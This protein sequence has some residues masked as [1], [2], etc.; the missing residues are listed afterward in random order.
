M[1]KKLLKY[2]LKYLF[3]RTFVLFIVVFGLSIFK[4]ITDLLPNNRLTSI[5]S[6]S[7]TFL[8]IGSL[9][10]LPIF[11]FVMT[12]QRYRR[13]MLSDEGYLTHTLPV[14]ESKILLS[15]LVAN[16]IISIASVLMVVAGLLI[17]LATGDFFVDAGEF[18]REVFYD[19]ANISS[20]WVALYLILGIIIIIL[21]IVLATIF[22]PLCQTLST[23]FEDKRGLFTILFM[24]VIMVGMEIIM[25]IV[26][27]IIM[28]AV[29]N[30]ALSNGAVAGVMIIY[31]FV[32]T[33]GIVAMYFGILAIIKK[34]LNLK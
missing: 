4:R 1:F 24:F 34:R 9:F 25:S 5:I 28:S 10:V 18:I 6:G 33:A 3:R 12:L 13:N 7:V 8:F 15:K 22:I 29:R 19:I 2:D 21:G 20:G 17:A 11:C 16:L 32:I 31:I 14:K 30:I 27:L 23:L 26:N